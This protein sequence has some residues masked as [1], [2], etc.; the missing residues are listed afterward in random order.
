MGKMSQKNHKKPLSQEKPTK[1]NDLVKV[2]EQYLLSHLS[3]ST[4][5][6]YK[7]ESS[8]FFELMIDYN[9]FELFLIIYL[10]HKEDKLEY[11][12]TN[13]RILS[14]KRIPFENID[15]RKKAILHF[16]GENLPYNDSDF[17]ED[18][19]FFQW[20]SWYLSSDFSFFSWL[21]TRIDDFS[22]LILEYTPKLKG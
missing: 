9:S 16:K 18:R 5:K 8:E 7:Q 6:H 21:F 4:I 17:K 2:F 14:Q 22:S 10:R 3:T 15:F 13:I 11:S 1:T 20:T 19:V 12:P